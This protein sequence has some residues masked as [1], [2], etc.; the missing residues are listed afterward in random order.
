MRHYCLTV[1]L[2]T[3]LLFSCNT[4]Q[5]EKDDRSVFRYNEAS[6]ITSL[7][8]AYASN[9]ANIWACNQL[10][11]GLVQLDRH[12]VPKPCIAKSW[13]ISNDGLQYVFHL[14]SDVRFHTHPAIAAGRSVRAADFVYSFLRICDEKTASPGSWIF[15]SIQSDENGRITGIQAPND[16]TLVIRLRHAFPPLLGLLASTYCSVV[17][18]EVIRATGKDF[19]KTPIGTGPFI[20]HAWE[21]R[22]ALVFHR[23]P[24]YFESD[25]VGRPLPYL[26]ALMISFISDKQSAFLAFLQGKIDFIS[27][28]DAGYKDDLL[29]TNGTLRPKYRGRFN[30]ETAPYL[31]TEYLGILADSSIESMKGSPLNDLRI[32]QAIN[33][34]FDRNEMIR[35]LRNGMATPGVHGMLPPGIPGYDCNKVKGYG[36]DP[37]LASAL[38]QEAGYPGGKGL[39]EITMSTTNSYQ[40]LCEYIQGQLARLGIRIRLE[41]NQ[42]GQHRQMVAKQQL[43]FFRGSWIADY[44]DGEN[45]L[46]LF[47]SGNKAPAG[48]NYTHFSDSEFDRLYD[49]SMKQSGL[50]ERVDLYSKMDSIVM[51]KSPVVVLYYDKIVRLT[52]KDIKGLEI[53]PMNLLTLKTVSKSTDPAN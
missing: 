4:V 36:Y 29:T 51:S 35:Y 49:E 2:L 40:D 39:P 1:I 31:N 23:N 48:P 5:K 10:F 34:G 7:D 26:D 11:N 33:Y 14:R 17:P 47:K 43:Q 30:M 53:N 24:K 12:L 13:E 32:R 28:L 22:T 9:Q 38:L 44:A 8:P 16:S 42:A 52:Q 41:V 20:F 27:G 45:Y 19:R 6:G 25:S 21:E 18:Q 50:S 15:Q 37:E 3:G 46:V